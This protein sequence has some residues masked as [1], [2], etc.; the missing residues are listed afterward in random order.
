MT[1]YRR[2]S[3][4]VLLVDGQDRVLLLEFLHEPH[5]RREDGT[6]WFT[7]GGGVAPGEELAVA[8]ARELAEE[9]GLRVSPAELGE[10]VAYTSGWADLGYAAGTFRDDFFFLRVDGHEVD[11]SGLEELERSYV[12]GHRWW[13]LPE[14]AGTDAAIVP[15]GLAGLLA[16]L[17]AGRRGAGPVALP[18]HH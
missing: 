11:D 7:P 8:A 12:I 16:D 3:A 5:G 10:P 9:V 2:R 14:L 18:W 15:N 17:L 6:K 1:G 13:A 4:R